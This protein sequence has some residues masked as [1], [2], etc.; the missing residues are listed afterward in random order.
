MRMVLA[1]LLALAACQDA[2]VGGSGTAP[3]QSAPPTLAA[4][5]LPQTDGAGNRLEALE[6]I[7]EGGLYCVGAE[8]WCVA[9]TS[10]TSVSVAQNA[11][12]QIALPARGV[13]W[14]NII[15]SQGSA[16]VG[17]IETETQSYSGG[18]GSAAHLVLFK[19][20]DGAA[21]EIAR[22]PYSGGI[23]IRACFSEED[24]AARADACHDQYEFVS[25]VRLDDTVT[26]GAPQIVLETAAATYPGRV[27]RG[28]DSQERPALTPADLV[29]ATDEVCSFRR[30][31]RATASGPYAPDTEL[32]ACTDYLEP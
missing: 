5:A 19:V 7:G 27:T 2:T 29:W 13:M 26:S 9:A 21:T 17:V 10:E 32:P 22:L 8:D 1:G 20:T 23:M 15:V 11:G 30:T 25:R 24:T 28:E 18:G 14:P 3:A 6:Q 4:V 16:I 31:Y 12:A